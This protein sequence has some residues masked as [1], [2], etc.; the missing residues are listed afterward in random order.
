M[1]TDVIPGTLVAREI[2]QMLKKSSD[3]QGAKKQVDKLMSKSKVDYVKSNYRLTKFQNIPVQKLDL[4][5]YMSADARQWKRKRRRKKKKQTASEEESRLFEAEVKKEETEKSNYVRPYD[6]FRRTA[7]AVQMIINVSHV[8]QDLLAYYVR[9][10][11]WYAILDDLEGEERKKLGSKTAFI[12]YVNNEE[13]TGRDKIVFD[14]AEYKK[15]FKSDDLISEEIRA[16]LNKM[17]GTRTEEE[18]MMVLKMMKKLSDGFN[19]YPFVVQKKICQFAFFDK[20][21]RDRV[22]IRRG[23][24]SDGLYFVLSGAVIENAPNWKQHVH[25]KRG[26]IFGEK[27]LECGCARRSDAIIKSTSAELLFLHRLDYMDIFSQSED[28]GDPKILNICRKEIVFQHFPMEVLEKNPGTWAVLHYKFGRLIVKN[29]NDIEWI[30]VVKAGEARVIKHLSVGKI[31][32]SARRKK[33]QAM[34]DADDPFVKTKQLLNFVSA[35]DYLK[36]QYRLGHYH[37]KNP[38]GTPRIVLPKS[39]PPKSAPPTLKL[40]GQLTTEVQVEKKKTSQMVRP[41]TSPSV[42]GDGKQDSLHPP[43]PQTS[44][45]MNEPSGDET[46]D[47]ESKPKAFLPKLNILNL[48]NQGSFIKQLRLQIEKEKLEEEAQEE[49]FDPSPR[50]SIAPNSSRSKNGRKHKRRVSLKPDDDD[51]IAVPPFVQIETLQAGQVFGLRG[52]L[53]PDER[54]ASASLVSAGC[55]IL[56]INKKFFMM[57]VDDTVL[58]LVRMKYKPFPTEDDLLDRLDNNLQWEKYKQETVKEYVDNKAAQQSLR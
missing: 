8:C 43:R 58:G 55:D 33:V 56:Q 13:G 51:Q 48:N 19:L 34:V 44:A 28:A 2:D 7:K 26:D 11:S 18:A 29:S 50:S 12:T 27:D 14:F 20:Y 38:E 24:P 6:K 45:S 4:G 53:E 47:G 15:D 35:R 30:Y 21:Y 49:G 40:K 46:S 23:L 1:A 17:P 5:Q 9:N 52:I 10:E 37:P 22:I 57:H 42:G 39:S 16:I 54:G 3:Y 25:L 36:S 32:V 41:Q 31:S